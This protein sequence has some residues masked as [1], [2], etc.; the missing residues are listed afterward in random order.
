MN[1]GN[2]AAL[3]QCSSPLLQKK[4]K[5]TPRFTRLGILSSLTF[6]FATGGCSVVEPRAERWTPVTVGASWEVAQRNTGSY[7]RD[8]VLQ[9]T[10]GDGV[11]QGKP[12]VT[13]ANSQGLTIM[14][15]Q[16]GHWNAIVGRDGK[17]IMSW[18]PPLGFQYPMVVGATS[19]TAY[20]MT[21]G[22]SGKTIN[23]NLTCKVESY[24]KVAVRAGTFDAFKV[25]CSTD[26]GNEE[27]YWTN[28]A[29]GV[30]V[31]NHLRRTEKSPFGAGTQ[32]AE[33]VSTPT[34]KR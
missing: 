20:R 6:A 34:L 8:V 2:K 27:T 7:G 5:M 30:F 14:T 18:D 31:K 1:E 16:S 12:V 15:E 26:I 21:L 29:M 11:W 33:L 28:P 25:V 19:V 9:V 13:I 24:E 32:E 23:Y 17:A 10:R 22:A 3:S 4:L